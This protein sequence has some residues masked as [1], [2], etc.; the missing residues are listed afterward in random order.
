MA[1]PHNITTPRGSVIV[2]PNGKAELK[3]NP[4]FGQAYTNKF[5]KVQVFIDSQVIKGLEPYTPLR[6]SMMIKS[7]QLGT[8]IGSGLI[9]YL[10][11]YARRQYFNGREVGTSSTGGLRGRL[12]FAR[13]KAEKG[14]AFKSSVRSFMRSQGNG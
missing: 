13:W 9:R 7:A 3:W 11:P 1:N 14:D 12:W 10:A 5:G 4:G 8:T 6:T 2:T